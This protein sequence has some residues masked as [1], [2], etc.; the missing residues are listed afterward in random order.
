MTHLHIDIAGR[1]AGPP[2]P[3]GGGLSPGGALSPRVGPL[4]GR[5]V[6]LCGFFAFL[7]VAPVRRACPSVPSVRLRVRGRDQ[8]DVGSGPR[9]PCDRLGSPGRARP[10][11]AGGR[12]RQ[13]A[14]RGGVYAR[15]SG[16]GGGQDGLVLTGLVGGRG[17]LPRSRRFG[18]WFGFP[19]GWLWGTLFRAV[20]PVAD[21]R[22]RWRAGR[23]RWFPS[24]LGSVG[25]WLEGNVGQR[26]GDFPVRNVG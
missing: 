18:G 6:V 9:R 3:P 4:A 21:V 20:V 22:R 5:L 13:R 14:S 12:P 17:A 2:G 16:G 1:A 24:L 11:P 23:V 25:R 26:V 8:V 10:A 7:A 19:W 15:A